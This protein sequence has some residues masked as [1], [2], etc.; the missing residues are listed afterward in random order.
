[1][2]ADSS[3]GSILVAASVEYGSKSADTIEEDNLSA[4]SAPT[5]IGTG[6]NRTARRALLK[7]AKKKRDPAQDE[8]YDDAMRRDVA[9]Q[10][11]LQAQEPGVATLKMEIERLRLK[12]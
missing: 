7:R 11:C 5:T 3:C 1:M 8:S 12:L 4:C 10:C 6:S 2:A 9:T